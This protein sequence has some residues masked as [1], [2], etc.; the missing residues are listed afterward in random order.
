MGVMQ[1]HDAVTGTAKQAVTFDYIQRL[2]RG[3][4]ECERVANDATGEVMTATGSAGAP[5]QQF[6]RTLNLTECA[7]S[8]NSDRFVLTVYNPLIRPVGRFIRLPVLAPGYDVVSPSGER[9]VTQVH[10]L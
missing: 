1:H 7:V 3:F 6:C 2:A 5:V 10:R 8:E 9:L 4:S